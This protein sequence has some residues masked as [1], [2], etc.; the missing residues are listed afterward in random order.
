M[1]LALCNEVLADL[2]FERQCEYA[3]HLGYQG[4]EV[5]PY[6]LSDAPHRIAAPDVARWRRVAADHGLAL[7]GL[8]WLLVKP[9]GLSITS[10][11]PAVRGATVDVMRALVELCAGLGGSYLVHGSPK[12]RTIHPG[13]PRGDAWANAQACF[14]AVAGAAARAGVVYCIEPLSA[15]QTPIVNRIEEAVRM[16]REIDSPNLR[17]MLDTSSAG[18]AESEPVAALVDRW[19][20][21]G[22]VAHVQLNDRNRRGPGQGADRFAPVLAALRRHGY[23]GWVAVEPFDYVPDGRGSAARAIGY[24]RGLLEALDEADASRAAAPGHGATTPGHGAA[25]AVAAPVARV[26]PAPRAP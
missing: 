11:D 7:C 13:Q 16:V 20:P 6:T 23:G 19:L 25:A 26:P 21:S 2:P 15:D 18:L 1:R 17:T 9:E 5:A 22:F 14:A 4:L 24:V 3:A 10:P 12:Q 8:H